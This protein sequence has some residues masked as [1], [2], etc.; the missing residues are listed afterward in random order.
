M[1]EEKSKKDNYEKALAAYADAMKEFQKGRL[2]K[3]QDLFRAFVEKYDGEKELVDR[4]NLYVRIIQ[5]RGKKESISLKT[6]DDYFY[7]SVYKINSGDS[8]GAMK[9]LEKALS[10]GEEEGRTHYLM[11]NACIRLG[12]SEDALEHLKK[13]FQKDKFFKIMAQNES[14]FEPLWEDKKFKLLTRMT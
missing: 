1:K 12:R 4:A 14:D 13:A 7:Y 6:I 10:L 11:A 2:E 3:A 8:E 5:E 9:L